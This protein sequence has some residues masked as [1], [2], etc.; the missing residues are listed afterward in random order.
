MPKIVISY[1]R[2]DTAGITGRIHDRLRD[3]YGRDAVFRDIDAIPLGVDFR[4]HLEQILN[5]ADAMV[6]IIGE[7]WL[8]KPK[9]GASRISDPTDYVR[10]EVEAALRKGIPLVPVLID[11]TR[12]PKSDD[13]P[14]SIRDLMFRHALRVDQ[15]QDF[16]ANTKRLV[17]GLD[18]TLA[19]TVSVQERPTALPVQKEAPVPTRPGGEAA[20][21]G[22]DPSLTP[23]RPPPIAV[24]PLIRRGLGAAAKRLL[25]GLDRT[26]ASTVSVQ[27]RPTALPVQKEAPVPTR[28]GGEAATVGSD[29]SLTPPRPPPIAVAPLIRRGLGAAAIVALYVINGL[30]YLGG[31][32]WTVAGIL[33]FFGVLSRKDNA[34]WP[35]LL[36]LGLISLVVAEL[37]RRRMRRSGYYWLPRRSTPS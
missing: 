3:H 5:D 8:G 28:P 26:L 10:L 15:L 19:S 4:K 2:E 33:G 30:L 35:L 13:L 37:I 21:V 17:D 18:R 31:F 24:A 25:D 34:D 9:R 29:P 36:L 14:E 7:K 27:E 22:S 16:D 6:C 11:D 20:T 32:V 12:M 23:P 1:R